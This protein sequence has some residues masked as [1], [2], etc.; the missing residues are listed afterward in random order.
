VWLQNETPPIFHN[1]QNIWRNP[2]PL[3]NVNLFRI[4][5]WFRSIVGIVST[6]MDAF[7]STVRA[8]FSFID[9]S[10]SDHCSILSF[11]VSDGTTNHVDMVR[12]L[13]VE[14]SG[15][16]DEVAFLW[17]RRLVL[18]RP[19]SLQRMTVFH[20]RDRLMPLHRPDA[21]TFTFIPSINMKL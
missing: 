9:Q 14:T 21:G 10:L 15:L 7:T 2:I 12:K 5:R 6:S 1:Y 8:M 3:F 20:N 16:P 13:S 4:S 17:K 11:N 18:D 19:A